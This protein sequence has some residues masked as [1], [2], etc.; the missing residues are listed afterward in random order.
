LPYNLA[1]PCSHAILDEY[2][3]ISPSTRQLFENYPTVTSIDNNAIMKKEW[4]TEE[5]M[6]LHHLFAL[7]GHRKDD[8]WFRI[9]KELHDVA[10]GQ[11]T[12]YE[13]WRYG[14]L[15]KRGMGWTNE[16]R[17]EVSAYTPEHYRLF[18][19]SRA[20][21]DGVVARLNIVLPN[22]PI[23]RDAQTVTGAELVAMDRIFA[24]T[25]NTLATASTSS[26]NNI[27]LPANQVAA[28]SRPYVSFIAP[29][30]RGNTVASGGKAST[31]QHVQAD[32]A[33]SAS[34]KRKA[35]LEVPASQ[36]SLPASSPAQEPQRQSISASKRRQTAVSDKDS[37]DKGP[38][39]NKSSFDPDEG[40]SNNDVPNLGLRAQAD[41][42][43]G[44]TDG[45]L[46]QSNEFVA[47]STQEKGKDRQTS[48]KDNKRQDADVANEGVR[49]CQ[50]KKDAG[51]DAGKDAEKDLMTFRDYVEPD[52]SIGYRL[53]TRAELATLE[54]MGNNQRRNQPYDGDEEW[55]FDNRDYI[56]WR[57]GL[58]F[59]ILTGPVDNKF[60][61]P[62][63]PNATPEPEIEPLNPRLRLS[64]FL[65]TM[66]PNKIEE[67]ARASSRVLYNGRPGEQ[68]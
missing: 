32:T 52:D 54:S 58:L 2:R 29:S 64:N 44:K 49:T 51:K 13:D 48:K 34:K 60:P 22:R 10:R 31:A 17:V 14:G 6:T 46:V 24:A 25:T 47:P 12:I 27:T 16:I 56:R 28:N 5:R 33:A 23:A 63:D 11:T 39:D 3:S 59:K 15:K 68:M 7:M 55:T 19:K 45:L 61:H 50:D 26:N 9:Y 1:I 62:I 41:Y 57:Q 38:S 4:F 30:A 43:D 18:L 36:P 35:S 8:D 37:S 20:G 21:I 42:D 67:I 40:V 66:F 53:L 65:E